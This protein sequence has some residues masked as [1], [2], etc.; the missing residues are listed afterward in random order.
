LHYYRNPVAFVFRFS[1]IDPVFKNSTT[2]PTAQRFERLGGT[3]NADRFAGNR[4]ALARGGVGDA[5]RL[6][7]V[8]LDKL[9]VSYQRHP[10]LLDVSGRFEGGSLTAVVGPNGA[11]KSTL[12]KSMV[13][14]APISG[15]SVVLSP[16]P[17]C[18]AYLPQLSQIERDFPIDVLDCVL[19]GNW[20][21]D[22]AWR[23]N[24]AKSVRRA[25]SAL[26]TVGLEGYGSR[27]V[28]ALS[29]GQMQ[30]VLF[31]RLILQDAQLILLDEPFNAL[32]ESTSTALMA[33]VLEWHRQQRTVIAV[34]HDESQVRR[35]FPR[36]LWLARNVVAWGATEQVLTKSPLERAN[37]FPR[38]FADPAS[39]GQQGKTFGFSGHDTVSRSMRSPQL[40]GTE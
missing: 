25:I 11:G 8:I 3:A 28:S 35:Y 23:G 37:D 4:L 31:A 6:V 7:M 21:A 38:I 36:T 22:G 32:D 34:L 29:T 5:G 18:V 2:P 9:T 14:L 20:P 30:R 33:L 19:L 17:S 40:R 13:G 24:T 12:L 39:C 16:P 15:G 26:Q 10:A 1:Q 27:P